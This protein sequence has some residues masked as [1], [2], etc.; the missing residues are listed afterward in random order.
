[1][2]RERWLR[3]GRGE[4]R[5]WEVGCGEPLGFLA[6]FGGLPRWTPFLDE[7]ARERRVIAPSLPGFPGALG[8]DDLDGVADWVIAALDLLDAAGLDGA[9]L[10][11]VSLGAMLAAEVAAF[12]RR[13]VR[14]LVLVSPLGLFDAAEPTRDVFASTPDELPGL[15]C[16]D[17]TRF[18]AHTAPP[19]GEDVAEWTLTMTRAAQASARLL[20]PLGDLGLRRRLHRIVVPTLVVTGSEDRI[21]PRSYAQRITERVPGPATLRTVRG[22]GHQ[23]DLDAPAE[24]ARELGEFFAAQGG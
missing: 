5:V 2:P 23:V 12:S 19:D 9:D 15:L 7:M 3:M 10:A 14:R 13:S 11:G 17:P 4:A 18:V 16:A 8:H 24:L 22:A 20:W 1:M 21:L 6:G